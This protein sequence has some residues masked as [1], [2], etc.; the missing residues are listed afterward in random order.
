[1]SRRI[2]ASR[3]HDYRPIPPARERHGVALREHRGAQPESERAAAVAERL[4]ALDPLGDAADDA[5]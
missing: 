4:A 1:M 5:D 3:R 2:R